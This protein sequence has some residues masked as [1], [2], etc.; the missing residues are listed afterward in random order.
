MRILFVGDIVSTSGRKV[1]QQI[2]PEL[3]KKYNIEFVIANGENSAGGFGINKKTYQEL[4]EAQIDL[5]TTGNHTWDNREILEIVNN[6]NNIIVPYNFLPWSPGKKIYINPELNLAVINLLGRTFLDTPISPLLSIRELENQGFFEKNLNIIID[7]HA[8]ATAEKYFFSYLLDG[9]ISAL[10]G[11]HTHVQTNDAKI[12]PNGTFH[13]TDVGMCGSYYS[14]IGFKISKILEKYQTTLNNKFEPERERP[15]IFN[16]VLLEIQS[17]KVV[18][19][20]VFNEVV[21]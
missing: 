12:L 4:M 16:A 21:N 14:I 10:I 2:I 5:I 1:C 19:F 13:I 9:K 17:A 7:F 6:V 8:E 11:T 15:Y 18:S 3:R 20:K